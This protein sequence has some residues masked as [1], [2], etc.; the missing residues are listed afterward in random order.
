MAREE[1]CLDPRNG[2]FVPAPRHVI[3]GRGLQQ[4]YGQWGSYGPASGTALGTALLVPCRPR[5][6]MGFRGSARQHAR[7]QL[8]WNVYRGRRSALDWRGIHCTLESRTA[9]AD[10]LLGEAHRAGA[11]HG[12]F[13]L[14][15]RKRKPEALSGSVVV[16]LQHRTLKPS[17]TRRD[18]TLL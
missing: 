2:D 6:R 16:A 15:V 14:A 12:R 18:D 5:D 1:V 13:R 10:G 3:P 4:L 7:H 17:Y 11:G 8:E 9:L